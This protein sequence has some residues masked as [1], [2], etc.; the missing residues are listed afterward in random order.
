MARDP[1]RYFRVEARE[2]L[3]QLGSAAL[4]LEKDPSAAEVSRLLRLAHT[5]KGA[6]RVVKQREIAELAHALEDAL[7]P[8]REGGRAVPRDR[9]DGMLATIDAMGDQVARLPGPQRE[10]AVAAPAAAIEPVRI[11][12]TEIS[13]VDALIEGLGEAYGELASMRRTIRG[14]EG[15]RHLATQLAEQLSSLRDGDP[16]RTVKHASAVAKARSLGEEV[17]GAIAGLERGLAGGAERI[18]RELRQAR[19][20]TERLRLVPAGTVMNAL[21]RLVRDSAHGVAKRVAF[22]ASGADVRLDGHVLD[23]VQ[24]AL[25]QLVRNAVA[26]GIEPEDERRRAGKP[27]EGRVTLE[28]SRHGH[29]V[30]IRCRDDGRGVDLEAVRRALQRK[31]ALPPNADALGSVDLMGLLLKG[32]LTTSGV[33]SELSGRGIGL[34]VVR[35]VAERLG[36]E[37]A[38]RT[39]QGLGTTVEL[40]VPVSLASLEVLVIEAGGMRAAVPIDAV[41]GTRRVAVQDVARAPAGD[42]IEHEDRLVA[43]VPLAAS[44]APNGVEH[45]GRALGKDARAFSVV[46]LTA[47]NAAAALKVDRIL[48][49]ETI[50]LRPLPALAPAAKMVSGVHLDAEGDPRLVL[51]P[52]ALVNLASRP[53]ADEGVPARIARPILVIDD[54][55]TTR[56]LEQSILES[57]G[58][59]VALATSGE[60]ALDMARRKAYGLF[61]VDIEMPGM[62]GFAFVERS[63]ADPLL[64]DVPCV[65]VTSRDSAQD[66]DR[67][68]SVGACG[69]IVKSEFDQVDFL[70]RIAKL[71]RQ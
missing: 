5:L 63:R 61:L 29:R 24:P 34:D 39:F 36:G 4:G 65:L 19:E 10:E 55:L 33:V 9:V 44:L 8:Y 49:S 46:L 18:D 71:V 60:E 56:M 27:P 42:A 11:V 3:D 16:Q 70:D 48:G 57:A 14:A 68:E 12:R 41:R 35:E 62:D 66:R 28:I 26:H 2:L 54:S 1:F 52:A 13:D 23:A 45:R 64:R 22:E 51:D 17:L 69:Y 58:Y 21:Q 25:V 47:G 6:A 53:A 32:G 38:V 31:G 7:A 37:V 15:A 59:E 40:R 20:L 43:L 30:L 50:M 67:G